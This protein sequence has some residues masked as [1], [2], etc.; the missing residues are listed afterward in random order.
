MV[1]RG[2]QIEDERI[3]LNV[4]KINVLFERS[5]DH[6]LKRKRQQHH[7]ENQHQNLGNAWTELTNQ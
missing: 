6:P 5:Y 3:V 2:L 1:E 4:L 7:K